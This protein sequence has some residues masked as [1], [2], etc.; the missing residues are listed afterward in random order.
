MIRDVFPKVA[1]LKQRHKEWGIYEADNI[2]NSIIGKAGAEAWEWDG[3]WLVSLTSWLEYKGRGQTKT[4]YGELSDNQMWMALYDMLNCWIS[5]Y[6]V[7]RLVWH[8]II[9]I[10]SFLC[11]PFA[12]VA[13]LC[14]LCVLVAQSY[15]TLCDPIDCSPPG[16]LVHGI[17]QAR[18]LEGVAMPSSRGST[19]PRD[20]T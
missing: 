8:L 9:T 17:L 14:V 10:Y 4:L 13:S 16:S 6:L 15:P 12:F 11:L 20:R 3:S 5:S 1:I 2:G 19:Q 18:I 7:R